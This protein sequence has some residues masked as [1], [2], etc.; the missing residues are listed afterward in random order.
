VPDLIQVIVQRLTIILSLQHKIPK[1][2]KMN[3]V[4]IM[5][6]GNAVESIARINDRL[7]QQE[8]WKATA[9]T[10]P[11]E[12]I[13]AFQQSVFDVILFS[14]GMDETEARKLSRLFRFQDNDVILI[15]LK[16]ND[17]PVTMIEEALLNRKQ[18]NKPVYAFNDDALRDAKF[19][20]HLS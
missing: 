10:I 7:N 4:Q 17:E 16:A 8:D 5:I 15:S 20:I 19:N 3:K 9:I 6:V 12:A 14:D 11:E 13:S 2:D 18:L 1:E